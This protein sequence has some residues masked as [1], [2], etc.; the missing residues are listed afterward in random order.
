LEK[1][2][3]KSQEKQL[4]DIIEKAL[5]KREQE[6]SR[7]L[8]KSLRDVF[9]DIMQELPSEY[10]WFDSKGGISI[11]KSGSQTIERE[12]EPKP[13]IRIAPGPLEYITIT[14]KVSQIEPHERKRYIVRAWTPNDELIPIGVN[15][16]WS[17][18]PS[19]LCSIETTNDECYLT[20]GE[21]EGELKLTVVAYLENITKQE[22][23]D[24]LILAK[25]SK[26]TSGSFPIPKGID[27]P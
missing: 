14:P 11:I 18:K 21:N 27:K 25:S 5:E 9:Q 15:F 4:K 6:M 13:K 22:S 12:S 24:I 17:I 7:D 26:K 1:H 23:V 19:N 16:K 10:N 3:V 2:T 20:A 8:I